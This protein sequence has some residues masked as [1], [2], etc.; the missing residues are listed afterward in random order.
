MCERVMRRLAVACCGEGLTTTKWYCSAGVAENFLVP[1]MQLSMNALK[2]V[3]DIDLLVS[4]NVLQA[5][6]PS[7]LASAAK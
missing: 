6:V 2:A 4:W 7:Q 5:T 1:L 3:L